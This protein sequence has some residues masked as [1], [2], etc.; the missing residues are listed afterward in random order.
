MRSGW[1]EI[2]E[3]GTE[4]MENRMG[5]DKTTGIIKTCSTGTAVVPRGEGMGMD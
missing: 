2:G 1:Y 4:V 5:M 3:R